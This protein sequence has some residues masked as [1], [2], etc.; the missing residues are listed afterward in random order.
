M[1]TPSSP[2]YM[3]SLARGAAPSAPT[4][5]PRGRAAKDKDKVV[6][7]AADQPEKPEK[8]AKKKGPA[9]KA[10]TKRKRKG[11][12]DGSSPAASDDE[13]SPADSESDGA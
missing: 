9:K 4:A 3:Q 8:P 2:L 7:R 13:P 10:G 11:D 1:M 6:E 5:K 12:D